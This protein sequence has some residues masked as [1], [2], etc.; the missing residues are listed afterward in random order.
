[1]EQEFDLDAMLE[2]EVYKVQ[3]PT[4][5]QVA[6]ALAVLSLVGPAALGGMPVLPVTIQDEQRRH[7]DEIQQTSESSVGMYSTSAEAAVGLAASQQRLAYVTRAVDNIHT[8]DVTEQDVLHA[9][10]RV[11][12]GEVTGQL[13][14]RFRSAFSCMVRDNVDL[15]ILRDNEAYAQGSW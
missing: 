3:M 9:A 7:R 6:A 11:F 10:E 4:A 2:R 13:E 12:A 5:Q 1:M 14:S 8:H 15:S